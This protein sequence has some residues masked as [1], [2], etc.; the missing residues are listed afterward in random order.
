MAVS[1]SA[2]IGFALG[3]TNWDRLA[4]YSNYGQSVVN[5]MGPGGDFVLPGNAL[6]TIAP[7][8]AP[9]WVFDLVISPGG[10][11]N[12]YFFAA[13]TSMATPHV[14]GLAALIV[15]K[16]GHMPPAQ[17]KARIEQSAADILKPGADPQSG[18][19][20]IDALAALE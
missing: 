4:S 18:K 10:K 13:G 14:S 5:V 15:G 17:L 9:C 19:G 3:N 20:R 2:P 8:T 7:V 12:R 11:G 1:A 16:F 6:C